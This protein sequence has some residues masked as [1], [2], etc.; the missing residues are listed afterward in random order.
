MKRLLKITAWVLLCLLLLCGGLTL[1]LRIPAVQDYLAHY[2]VDILSR[3]LGTKVEIKRFGWVFYRNIDMEGFNMADRAGDTL[4]YAGRLNVDIS[5]L[6]LLRREVRIKSISLQDAKVHLRTDT[7]GDL[8]L[9]ALFA[10]KNTTAKTPADSISKPFSLAIALNKL[11]LSNTDF[12]YEDKKKH[13][14]VKVLVPTCAISMNELALQKKLIDIN[15]LDIDGVNACVTVLQKDENTPPPTSKIRFMPPGW[16]LRWDEVALQHSRFTYTD[17]NKP[18]R[19]GANIDFAHLLLSDINLN[20]GRGKVVYDSISADITSL[21]AREKSGFEIRKLSG[22]AKIST[23]DISLRNLDLLTS[24]SAISAFLSLGYSDF[25]D[26]KDFPDK[27]VMKADLTKASLSLRDLNYFFNN[28]DKVAHNTINISGRIS[29]HLNDLQGKNIA[30]STGRGTVLKCNFFTNGLPVLQESSLNLRIDQFVTS[31]S[32]IRAFYPGDFYPPGFNQLGNISFDGDFDG[33]VSDFVTK[34]HLI[35][36]IGSASSDLNFKYNL[37]T[38][39]SAY[40]GELGLS[41]FELGRWFG[42]T[43]TLG[44]VSLHANIEGG[45]LK[46]ETINAKLL[47]DISSL[48]VR[49]HEYK[50]MKVNGQVRGRFFSGDL[51]VKDQ[52]LNADF[53]GTVDLAGQ[54]PKYKFE[55]AVR[56]ANLRELNLSKDTLNLSG[57]VTA[58]FSGRKPDDMVGRVTMSDMSV[59]HGSESATIR[60]IIATSSLV[61]ADQK[62]IELK[63]DNIEGRIAGNFSFAALPRAIRRYFNYTF[64]KSYVDTVGYAPQQF[65]FDLRVY[66]SSS[67]TRVIDPKFKEIRNSVLSGDM[68]SVDHVF[69]IKGSIPELVYDKYTVKNFDI[70]GTSKH[71]KIDVLAGVN[72]VYASDSLLIDTLVSHSYS[73][74]DE[75]R[76]DV[77]TADARK[78]NKAN[79]TA[80]VKPLTQS[81]ELRFAPSEVWLGGNKWTFAPDNKVTIR[82]KQITTDGVIFASGSQ[83]VKLESYLKNDTSTSI[84]L[85]MSDAS[86]GDFLNIFNRKIRDVRATLNGSVRVEDVFSKPAPIANLELK[87]IYFGKIAIGT[88]KVN[89]AIDNVAKKVNIDANIIGDKTDINVKG[90]Y[91]LTRQ[92]INLDN[93]IKSVNLNFL[94]NPF[95]IKYVKDVS[96]YGTARLNLHGPISAPSLT[97]ILRLNNAKVTVSY[98][99]TTYTLQDEDIEFGDGYIDVGTIDVIDRFKNIAYGKGRIYHDHFRKV[100]FD[101][102]VVGDNFEIMNTSVKD[103]PVFYGNGM[104]KGRIDFTGTLPIV[105]INAYAQVKPNTHCYIP[106]NNSY[107][108]NR[109]SFYRFVNPQKDTVKVKRKEDI[110]VAGI[111][112]IL[113]LDVTPDGILDIVLDPSA[114]DVLTSRGNGFMR[115]EILRTGE[116]NIYGNYT[117]QQGNYLFTMQNIVNKHFELDP[118]GTITFRGDVYNAQLNADAVYRVTTSTYDLI[119]DLLQANQISE[120]SEAYQ[121]SKNRIGVDLLLKLKGVLQSPE[122]AFDIR[123]QDPDAMIRS[124]VDNKIQLMRTTESEMNKQVFGLLVM[125]RFLPTTSAAGADPLTKGTSLGNSA[126]NTVSEFLSSQLSLYLGSFF[127]NI[128]VKD[129]DVN[130]NYKQYDQQVIGGLADNL[131]TRREIQLALTKKFFNNRLS[132]NVGGN[133]DFGDNNS[134]TSTSTNTKSTNFTGDFQIEYVL[135]K[136]GSW[137]AKTYNRNDYDNFRQANRNKTG[138]GISYRQDFDRWVDLF[139][140]KS[141]KPRPQPIP[142]AKPEEAPK[143]QIK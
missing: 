141:K 43:S 116:F 65:T 75:F 111:N 129:F 36:D 42:D 57:Y 34:G 142:P 127:D 9:L 76:F 91:D 85:T 132:I 90:F 87:D 113:D 24:H 53:K 69:N 18:E 2:A 47:G 7:A 12:S 130:F 71:G 62:V 93:S 49:G 14:M 89:S 77:R 50:D 94:N 80:Y 98:I 16:V 139:M 97:G 134:A 60:S 95:F 115:V 66:D 68:N 99:N 74:G 64:T 109:Y 121:R 10:G 58:D 3:Q 15:A 33:F 52:Y 48:T 138:V 101:L 143:T 40:S 92:E 45:G 82:G 110:R 140:R 102:H 84:N 79:I 41:N 51:A 1:S 17:A 125:K 31:V 118:G 30:I 86:L 122:V 11:N 88:L 73:E 5:Y 126:A 117:I 28:L 13:L 78:Y 61:S 108:T 124:Y 137:R 96:G 81:T 70:N 105:N 54:L 56:N 114:G 104:V 63:S 39:K 44:R 83:S 112:F 29:G 100:T 46:P 6:D 38:G 103:I 131:N 123:P 107:E 25:E 136:N 133:L 37:Q 23:T 59:T 120:T 8:N 19:S 106:I 32:D 55:L 22:L 67:I 135:D 20:A 35:T 72:K 27:V 26:F 119:A 21:M 4:I 128:N